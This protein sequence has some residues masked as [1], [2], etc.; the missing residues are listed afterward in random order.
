MK[1]VVI[2]FTPPND[3]LAQTAVE[4]W[5]EIDA[6]VEKAYNKEIRRGSNERAASVAVMLLKYTAQWMNNVVEYDDSNIADHKFKLQFSQVKF[7]AT[8]LLG[9]FMEENFVETRDGF[10]S[11]AKDWLRQWNDSKLRTAI[12]TKDKSNK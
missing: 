11:M 12:T 10:R 1:N 2:K 9:G 4:L 3:D 5:R 6:I 7:F 8:D